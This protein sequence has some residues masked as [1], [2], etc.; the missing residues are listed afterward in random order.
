M[1]FRQDRPQSRSR[2]AQVVD[3]TIILRNVAKTDGRIMVVAKGPVPIHICRDTTMILRLVTVETATIIMTLAQDQDQAPVALA[4]KTTV[5]TE[6]EAITPTTPDDAARA[7]CRKKEVVKTLTIYTVA[8]KKH[9]R[10][11]GVYAST[12]N[13]RITILSITISLA[14]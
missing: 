13:M 1:D 6:I 10:P 4:A 5:D 14:I 8:K 11:A 7:H 12:W 3:Q 2:G 9:F